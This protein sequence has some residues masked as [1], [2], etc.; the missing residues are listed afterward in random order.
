MS[1]T[2]RRIHSGSPS[3]RSAPRPEVSAGR[4]TVAADTWGRYSA[5]PT[6]RL[7]PPFA[8]GVAAVVPLGFSN[9]GYDGTTLRLGTLA[10]L[11][12][13][14]GAHVASQRLLLSRWVRRGLAWVRAI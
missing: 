11:G 7:L 2:P 4:S 1:T 10:A 12:V 14:A 9:G 13:C 5:V 3:T 6:L 8:T